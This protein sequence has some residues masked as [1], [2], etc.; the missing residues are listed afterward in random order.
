M[1]RMNQNRKSR[2]QKRHL[3]LQFL[4]QYT[5]FV[6]SLLH[7]LLCLVG[8]LQLQFGKGKNVT[9]FI[10]VPLINLINIIAFGGLILNRYF[11]YGDKNSGRLCKSYLVRGLRFLSIGGTAAITTMSLITVADNKA[12]TLIFAGTSN[13]CMLIAVLLLSIADAFLAIRYNKLYHARSTKRIKA[14]PRI[15]VGDP[16]K[17]ENRLI[18]LNVYKMPNEVLKVSTT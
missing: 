8:A 5:I 14:L 16:D 12:N 11:N 3:Q 1:H 4:L 7:C 15:R 9:F 13:A 10:S 2:Q 18:S 17:L 6:I